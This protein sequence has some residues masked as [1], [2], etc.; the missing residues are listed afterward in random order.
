MTDHT[1]NLLVR[2]HAAAQAQRFTNPAVVAEYHTL[3]RAGWLTPAIA[4][5][6]AMLMEGEAKASGRVS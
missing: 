2:A 1:R 4:W 6:L 5:R 3:R